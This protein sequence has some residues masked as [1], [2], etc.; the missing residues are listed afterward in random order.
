MDF[1]SVIVNSIKYR[2]QY[3]ML[4]NNNN[5]T[6]EDNKIYYKIYALSIIT[7]IFIAI[8]LLL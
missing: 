1:F 6:K 2:L 8:V 7:I 4:Y 5:T 3:V